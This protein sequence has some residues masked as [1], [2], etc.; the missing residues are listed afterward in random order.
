MEAQREGR[1]TLN[2]ISEE[3]AFCLQKTLREMGAS[4]TSTQKNYTMKLAR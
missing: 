2:K 1:R 3:E 4:C